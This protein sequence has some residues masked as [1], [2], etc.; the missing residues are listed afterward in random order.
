METLLTRSDAFEEALGAVFGANGVELFDQSPQHLVSAGACQLSI[1]HAF[2][3]R[4]LFAAGAPHSGTSLLRLQYEALLR[5]AWALYA[6][7]DLQVAKLTVPLDADS[8]QGAKNL[9]G[10]G[11][12][13][14]ALVREAPP[15]LTIPL[16]QFEAISVKALNSFV[17]SGIHP[18]IR[19]KEGIP[20]AL[21]VQVVRNSNGLMHMA[22]RLLAS[23]SGSQDQMNKTTQIYNH[24]QD[25]L[26]MG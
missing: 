5:G 18:L 22:Y 17:H 6:A 4:C 3:V 24:F 8:E 13:L 16:Q 12:M 11:D 2:A 14:R 7:N 25:C 26:P 23:L 15:G 9:P 21:A 19:S 1:E 10:A 20:L